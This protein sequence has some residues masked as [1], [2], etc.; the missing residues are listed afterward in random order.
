MLKLVI[1]LTCSPPTLI[2]PPDRTT[3]GVKS[4][5]SSKR[6]PLSGRSRMLCSV[7][8]EL[9]AWE[10][11][12]CGVSAV[13]VTLDSTEATCIS[14]VRSNACP[15][16]SVSPGA[17]Y[18][19]NP[20]KD[21]D[22]SY[23]P[24]RRF[25]MMKRPLLFV[26]TVRLSPVSTL[27]TVTVAFG[28]TACPWSTKSPVIDP[29]PLACPAASSGKRIDSRIEAKQSTRRRLL[30]SMTFSKDSTSDHWKYRREYFAFC[31]RRS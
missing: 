25:G 31:L 19:W 9:Y 29:D 10:V 5:R 16:L 24:A 17:V 3:P 27:V 13:T 20:V 6:R 23:L 4:A 30:L 18:C 21:A 2:V 22:T 12:I 8:T 28:T 14:I 26:S 15:T 11:L 1:P 7:T